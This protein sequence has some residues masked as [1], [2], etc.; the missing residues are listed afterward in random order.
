[1]TH[2]PLAYSFAPLALFFRPGLKISLICL[3]LFA[4]F[5]L[6]SF[7]TGDGIRWFYPFS[8]KFF[9]FCGK[10]TKGCHGR[11]G[12]DWLRAYKKTVGYKLEFISIAFLLIIL[13]FK[14]L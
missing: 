4:H 2:V 10:E 14:Y 13:G 3:G 6:D 9:L 1:L 8:K 12:L 5:I 7:F 11:Y